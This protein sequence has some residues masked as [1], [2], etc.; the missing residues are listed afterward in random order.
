MLVENQKIKIDIKGKKR[1][2]YRFRNLGYQIDDDQDF[3]YVKPEDLVRSDKNF[4]QAYCDDCGDDFLIQ[5]Y[6]YRK[7]IERKEK[8]LSTPYL[9]WTVF[10]TLLF[11]VHFLQ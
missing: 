8:I 3:L 7:K 6:T 2:I 1:I 4:L 5:N 11:V 9:S 10:L